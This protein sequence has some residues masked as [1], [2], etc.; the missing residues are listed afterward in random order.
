MFG[1]YTPLQ[2]LD[3]LADAGT[4]S[5]VVGSTNSLLLQQKD[6]Y[7]DILINVRNT[8]EINAQANLTS[9][10]RI[11]LTF[12][13]RPFEV[14]WLS[15]RLTGAGLTFLPRS[16]TRLGTMRIRNGQKPLGIWGLRS[17][18]DFSSKSTCLRCS[19]A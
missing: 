12:H 13:L 1:P 4:K 9:L 15:L 5:Y 16:S 17:S 3:L 18:S 7:S 10:T 6:R 14:P 8:L 19:P 2:Q 11:S